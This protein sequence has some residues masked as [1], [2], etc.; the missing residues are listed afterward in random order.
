[1][2]KK[3]K[4]VISSKTVI[5]ILSILLLFSLVI[6]IY[7]FDVKKTSIVLDENIVFFGDSITSGYKIEEF[8]PKNNVI[9]SGTSGDTTEN[10]LERMED[11]YKYNPSKVFI[12]IG[13]N[14]LN[15][16]KSIDEILD[17]IQRIVNNIKTNREYTNIYIES[18]YP[19]NR[20]VFEDKDYSFNNDISNDTIKELNDR[21]QQN[22]IRVE[23]TNTVREKIIEEAY[24]PRYGARPI[25]RYITKNIE[26]L[27]AHK[28]ID[29]NMKVGTTLIVDIKDNKFIITNK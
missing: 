27:I 5:I 1:M 21:L 22:Y 24:D 12:L 11:V 19:I 2:K 18:V 28:L 16:G 8:Y 25:K 9:N 6:N 4:I 13:I 17:N 23:I 14:D 29:E 20:N 26:N 10:L 7:F 3:K 15:R